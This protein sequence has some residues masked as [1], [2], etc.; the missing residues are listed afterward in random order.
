M[1]HSILT[2]I[3][4]LKIRNNLNYADNKLSNVLK[5]M[6]SGCK[7][8]NAKDD[9]AGSVIASKMSTKLS[10]LNSVSNNIQRG[11]SFLNTAEGAYKEISDILSRLRDLSLQASNDTSDSN[12]RNAIED[13]ANELTSEL[14]RI[15][16]S[17]KFGNINLFDN[18][19]TSTPTPLGG[20]RSS[21][22]TR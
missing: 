11:M 15:Q 3:S 6:A 10:G 13:E 9:A 2:D 18:Y 12:A 4:S 22:F 20:G 14:K 17:T 7:I 5:Q 16:S 19:Q 8:L 21:C 1:P